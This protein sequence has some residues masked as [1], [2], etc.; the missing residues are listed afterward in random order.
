MRAGVLQ[1]VRAR[2]R[3]STAIASLPCCSSQSAHDQNTYCIASRPLCTASRSAFRN[4][5]RAGVIT[6][7]CASANANVVNACST[8]LSHQH[9][10][11]APPVTT[12]LD[13]TWHEHRQHD[14]A[15]SRWRHRETGSLQARP[16]PKGIQP[17][18]T[19]DRGSGVAHGL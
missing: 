7:A 6:F 19:R 9:H 10:R 15:L 13:R 4:S 11:P 5:L 8:A 16:V 3:T 14:R 2:F 18:Q 17:G 12:G 1:T